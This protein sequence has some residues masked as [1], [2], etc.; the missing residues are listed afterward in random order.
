M[1]KYPK[2]VDMTL[3]YIETLLKTE[4]DVYSNGILVKDA[5]TVTYQTL[6]NDR[7]IV[8][9]IEFTEITN[10]ELYKKS[11]KL[12]LKYQ[13]DDHK[14]EEDNYDSYVEFNEQ[15]HRDSLNF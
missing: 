11:M 15:C 1:Q 3:D 10:S 12:K 5:N 9:K 4:E 6:F 8:E 7:N 2:L 13:F 14:A